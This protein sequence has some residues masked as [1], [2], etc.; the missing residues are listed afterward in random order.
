MLS[1]P[2]RFRALFWD[3]PLENVRLPEHA[4]Y[5]IERVM[6]RGTWDAMGWLLRT[7]DRAR[8]VDFLAR[9]GG[10]LPPR[11]RAYWHLMLDVVEPQQPGG[12]RPSW[13]D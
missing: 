2:E 12:G 13:A 1:V 7:F 10:R 3:V 6:S 9:K 5:V 4:D 11:E 8:L